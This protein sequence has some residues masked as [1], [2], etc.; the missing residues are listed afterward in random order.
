MNY[1]YNKENVHNTLIQKLDDEQLK[2]SDFEFQEL[3]EALLEVYKVIDI[4]VFSYIELPA[5][6]RNNK[7]IIN[8]KNNIQFCF[9]WCIQAYLY[10][11]EDHKNR[12]SYYSMPMNK[13]NLEGSEIPMKGKD[14]P[15]FERLITLNINVFELTGTVC[16]AHRAVLRPI[17][18]NTN[19]D[20]PQIDLLLYENQYCLITKLHCLIVKDSHMKYVC[21][22]C[23][24]AF[25]SEEVLNQSTH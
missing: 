6:Y 15:N 13:F 18:I 23:L 4:Q 5:K 17:H 1:I 8:M 2:G 25:S 14:I 9:L 19:Y 12:T 7:S 24:T 20:Q 11:V 16:E 22:R 21:R 10:P 3:E